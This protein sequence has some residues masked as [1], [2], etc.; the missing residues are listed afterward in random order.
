MI[1]LRQK[2]HPARFTAMS[3]LMA[4]LVGHFLGESF[5]TPE[6]ASVTVTSDGFILAML[7]GDIGY[8]DFIGSF[9]DLKRNWDTLL[10]AAELIEDEHAEASR[11]FN[12]KVQHP[13]L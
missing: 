1:D 6:I 8:N 3:P 2:L 7:K 13:S 5:T 10:D 11:L 4:A 12:D 9:A